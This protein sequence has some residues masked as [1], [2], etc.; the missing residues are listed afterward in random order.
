MKILSTNKLSISEYQAL[1]ALSKQCQLIDKSIPNLYWQ[2]LKNKRHG[3]YNFCCYD[4]DILIGFLSVYFFDEQCPEISVLIKPE[5]RR[6]KIMSAL[7]E[8]AKHLF[9]QYPQIELSAPET[10]TWFLKKLN[11]TFRCSDFQMIRN[12]NTQE[13]PLRP[14]DFI[15]ANLNHMSSLIAID[16]ACFDSNDCD[17]TARFT[18][19]IANEDYGIFLAFVESEFIGKVH[20]YYPE[21]TVFDLAILPRHQNKGWGK[22]L[23]R[24]S[25]NHFL[26]KS[27]LPI[28]LS[29]STDNI[30]ALK[31]YTGC[32]FEIE[33]QINSYR[34]NT[35]E[36]IQLLQR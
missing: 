31:L 36:F 13:D 28:R 20:C 19:L 14:L 10:T 18:Q 4:K 26:K 1:K 33:S 11:V 21:N 32:H 3:P 24:H 16:N 35:Q 22:E 30:G 17:M 2:T 27:P 29:V 7:V 23:L 34:T 6:K 8:Q 5:Y 25:I 9:S 12:K 15:K